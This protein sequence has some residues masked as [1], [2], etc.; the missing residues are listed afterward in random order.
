MS[1]DVTKKRNEQ[2]NELFG[3]PLG[4]TGD[5]PDGQLD[6]TD[7]GGLNLGIKDYEGYVVMVFGNGYVA[8][9]PQQ[10]LEVANALHQEAF[11]AALNVMESN[12]KCKTPV[13]FKDIDRGVALLINGHSAFYRRVRD[14]QQ[15]NMRIA[16]ET[17][18]KLNEKAQD[19]DIDIEDVDDEGVIE[20]GPNGWS[21]QLDERGT[22]LLG[23]GRTLLFTFYEA[24]EVGMWLLWDSFIYYLKLDDKKKD[25][26]RTDKIIGVIEAIKQ[27]LSSIQILRPNPATQQQKGVLN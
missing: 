17:R 11:Q 2:L 26:M 27:R 4:A 18:K 9:S 24:V 21:V 20:S 14:F 10:A 7:R 5:F 13:D 8:F 1:D 6:D 19:I 12:G 23:G 16:K 22:Y 3:A 25:P 15:R